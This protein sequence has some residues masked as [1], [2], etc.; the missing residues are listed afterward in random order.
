M[1]NENIQVADY[2]SDPCWQMIERIKENT[3]IGKLVEVKCEATKN[4]WRVGMVTATDY[5][6]GRGK[7]NYFV[8]IML[9]DGDNVSINWRQGGFEVRPVTVTKFMKMFPV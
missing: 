7:G 9:V 6:K 1:A 5:T 8:D 4:E 3:P 2:T